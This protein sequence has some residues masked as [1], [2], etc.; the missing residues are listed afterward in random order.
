MKTDIATDTTTATTTSTVEIDTMATTT[1]T[2]TTMTTPKH[3]ARKKQICRTL[4]AICPTY[5]PPPTVLGSCRIYI[6]H[7]WA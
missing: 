5:L 4:L 7:G 2:T 6:D 1:T 3:Q